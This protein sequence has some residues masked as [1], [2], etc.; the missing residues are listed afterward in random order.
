VQRLTPS[1]VLLQSLGITEPHE[2]DLEAIAWD[3]GAE[4]K[5]R[6]LEG[7][8]ARILGAGDRAIITIHQ[9]IY[10][11]R[12]RFS[13][14][15]E[16]GHWHHHR[17]KSFAC[18]TE[19]IGNYAGVNATSDAEKVADNYSADLLLPRYIFNEVAKQYTRPTFDTIFSIADN[20]D[21]S[22][23]CTAIRYVEYGNFPCMLVCYTQNGRKWFRR[24]K[25]VPAKLFPHDQL[26]HET[27]AIEVLFGEKS[28][29]NRITSSGDSWFNWWKADRYE[30]CEETVR[31]VEGET[32]TLLTW[33]N[34]KMLEEAGKD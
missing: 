23:T 30:V 7:C 25:D 18:R 17:G 28:K 16:L 29:T 31:L 2:I 1:E 33:K 4:V 32:L 6:N 11:R 14:G 21:V 26:D 24:N 5:Y 20:F 12:K 22:K 8:E 3:Q 27:E 19:D 34:E 10:D 9:G 15:H 13:I